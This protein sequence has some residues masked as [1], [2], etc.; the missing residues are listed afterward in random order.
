MASSFDS[1]ETAYPPDTSGGFD[2]Y[3]QWLNIP[4]G[5]RP[6]THYDL[7]G[8]EWM[9][10]DESRIRLAAMQRMAHV[11]KYQ[12][13][14]H[15]PLALKLLE[16][17]SR[18]YVCLTDP[19]L[20]AR[21]D[22]Q[23]LASRGQAGAA[24][25]FLPEGTWDIVEST[26]PRDGSPPAEPPTIARNSQPPASTIVSSESAE[27][28]VVRLRNHA[29]MFRIFAAVAASA[30]GTIALML[31]FRGEHPLVWLSALAL[32][33]LTT[34]TLFALSSLLDSSIEVILDLHHR[35]DDHEHEVR[36]K[37][38]ANAP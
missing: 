20:K 6:P 17:L 23:L 28:P 36:Q 11:R 31:F 15:G 5:R 26:Y 29:R 18:A 14:P 25:P 38:K 9:E 4:P 10:E 33:A 3:Q 13:S 21:Y 1:T 19:A 27:R 30:G 32:V 35:L 22:E 16:E 37:Q 7:L 2:A 34:S 8:L 24:W 12:I